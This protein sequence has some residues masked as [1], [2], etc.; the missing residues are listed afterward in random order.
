M[1][2]FLPVLAISAELILGNATA[3]AAPA[4]DAIAGWTS[5]GKFVFGSAVAASSSGETAITNKSQLDAKFHYYQYNAGVGTIGSEIERYTA[6]DPQTHVFATDRLNLTAILGGGDTA[7]SGGFNNVFGQ[8]SGSIDV[9]KPVDPAQFGFPAG[10]TL[11]VGNTIVL[12]SRGIYRVDAFEADGKVDLVALLG[13]MTTSPVRNALAVLTPF[14]ALKLTQATSYN[15]AGT[16]TEMHVDNIPSSMPLGMAVGYVK[17]NV[18][19]R[20]D[21]YRVASLDKTAKLIVTQKKFTFVGQPTT[22][23]DPAGETMIFVPPVRSGQI[24]SKDTFDLKNG[25]YA[26]DAVVNY[27][28]AVTTRGLNTLAKQQAL[29][30]NQPNGFWSGLWFY[31]KNITATT[32]TADEIDI[33]SWFDFYKGPDV[34]SAFTHGE[35]ATQDFQVNDSEWTAATDVGTG[36][37]KRLTGP[38]VGDV[39]LTKVVRSSAG[40]VDTYVNGKLVD[41]KGF[42]W[43]NPNPAEFILNLALGSVGG[44]YAANILFPLQTSNFDDMKLGVK[45]LAFYKAP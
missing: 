10:T 42:T 2:K 16:A 13:S 41:T 24:V 37:L 5:L 43:Q 36:Y 6:G 45:S 40:K 28:Q 23:Q 3:Y 9:S 29:P 25:D 39:R 14:Y 38:L 8:I 35:T 44:S 27:P 21:D 1:R 11:D 33:E 30:A 18:F 15:A 12:Q 34:F 32:N 20:N 17:N 26:F 19:Q 31:G 7:Y 4:D 22:Y